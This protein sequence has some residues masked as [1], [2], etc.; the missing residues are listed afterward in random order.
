MIGEIEAYDDSNE[1]YR[2]EQRWMT[3]YGQWLDRD[4]DALE[5][6]L[7]D[8]AQKIPAWM[9]DFLADL[10]AG[11]VSRGKG[12]RPAERDGWVERAI[13]AEVFAEWDKAAKDEACA[14]VA[15]RRGVNADVI[16]GVVDKLQRIGITRD[17]WIAW[18]QPDWR[19]R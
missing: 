19:N 10:A 1:D 12:G 13:V 6:L 9:R 2:A 4:A 11:K 14:T 16:R 5:A 17:K 15:D 3:A 18:G 7:R 8:D